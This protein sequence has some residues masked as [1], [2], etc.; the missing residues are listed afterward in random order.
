MLNAIIKLEDDLLDNSDDMTDVLSFFKNQ[1]NIFNSAVKLI[2]D[3]QSEKDYLIAEE[4]AV[5]SLNQIQDII[6]LEKPYRRI[7]ELPTLIQDIKNT[8]DKLLNSKK[9]DIKAEIQS[10]MAEIHQT[11][12]MLKHK[13]IVSKADSALQAKKDAVENATSLTS[14]DAMVVHINGLKQQYLRLLVVE[15][16]PDTD[17]VTTN[18]ANICYTAKLENEEDIDKYLATVK[19]NLLKLLGDHDILHII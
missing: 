15:E 6:K 19:R 14:L 7:S 10:A 18:R 3:L 13:D 4:S 1:K 17:I 11:A 8:Y 12:D 5:K 16:K 9:D 2:N